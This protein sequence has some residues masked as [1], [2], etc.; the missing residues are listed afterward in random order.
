[1]SRYYAYLDGA[2]T[3]EATFPSM[4]NDSDKQLRVAFEHALFDTKPQRK[5]ICEPW[6]YTFYRVLAA[7]SPTVA[8]RDYFTVKFVRTPQWRPKKC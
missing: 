2:A 3:T 7:V 1:M 6:Q 8:I 4:F 5:Y